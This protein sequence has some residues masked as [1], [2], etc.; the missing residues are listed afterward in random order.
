MNAKFL[1]L[2]GFL[3][4]TYGC[5]HSSMEVAKTDIPEDDIIASEPVR[6]RPD[7]K[8][9]KVDQ[10]D[11]GY[12]DFKQI[13]KRG[14]ASEGETV[15]AGGNSDPE[16]NERTAPVDG[17]SQ[18]ANAEAMDAEEDAVAPTHTFSKK[19][20]NTM[21][22]AK[23][24][25]GVKTFL[26]NAGQSMN[27]WL[28]LGYQKI[29]PSEAKKKNDFCIFSG[30][31]RRVGTIIM[32]DKKGWIDGCHTYGSLPHPGGYKLVGCVRPPKQK[33]L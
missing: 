8:M 19:G 28:N 7:Q 20:C 17:V 2:T 9:A 29:A 26:G 25:L 16:E 6:L 11:V 27:G 30:G 33:S 4:F 15:A 10:E 1:V 12:S 14:I 21:A 31:A 24:R 18:V 32:K 22:Y 13:V 23:N 3:L 5:S